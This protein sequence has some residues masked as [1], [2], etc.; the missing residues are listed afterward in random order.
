[1]TFGSIDQAI[2]DLKNGQL[3]VVADDEDRENEGDLV[4]AAEAVTPDLVNFM[5]QHGRGLICVAL[6]PTTLELTTLGLREPGDIVNLEVD[7]LAKY[8]EKL[9]LPH[10]AAQEVSR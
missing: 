9:A 8:V 10:V 3:I 4:C 5:L 1:M 7:V 6:I 2:A